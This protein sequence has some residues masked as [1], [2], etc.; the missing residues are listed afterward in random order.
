[1][2]RGLSLSEI[3]ARPEVELTGITDRVTISRKAQRDG[4]IKGKNAVLLRNEA[5]ARRALDEARH[6]KEAMNATEKE[7][8]NT[9]LIERLKTEQFFH[10]ANL[11]VAK[12]AVEKLI[13]ERSS[14]SFAEMD[15]ASRVISRSQDS[16]LGKK[17][18]TAVQT[19]V[20][21]TAP[22]VGAARYHPRTNTG[23]CCATSLTVIFND[24]PESLVLQDAWRM[25]GSSSSTCSATAWQC[26]LGTRPS[27]TP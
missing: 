5:E 24:S 11:T 7:V 2:S 4:W 14:I 23:G 22:S 3:V 17:P 27:T 25:A 18:D 16:A 9:L 15:A 21:V 26:M 10:N 19:N 20:N 1:M 12:T 13:K 6:E 8:H